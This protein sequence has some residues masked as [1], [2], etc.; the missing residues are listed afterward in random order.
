M[1]NSLPLLALLA[2]TAAC[3]PKDLPREEIK[4]VLFPDKGVFAGY[5]FGDSWQD[6]KA[7]H[8]DYFEVR[9]DEHKQLR[10]DVGDNAGS[11]GYYLGFGL[12]G[13]GKVV[14]MSVNISGKEQNAVTVRELLDDVIAHYDKTIG[15]GGCRRTGK[16]DNS[17]NCIWEAPGKPK[18]EVMYLEM[19]DLHSGSLD[20]SVKPPG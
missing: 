20:V 9:D 13:A 12:D 16:D 2:F 1:R 8:A 11:N 10:R 3:G 18:V 6:I 5:D 17:S 4:G 15:K 14:S 7:K 19:R